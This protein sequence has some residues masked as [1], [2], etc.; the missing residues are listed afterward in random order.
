VM[1]VLFLMP[2]EPVWDLSGW[3]VLVFR[4][5]QAAGLTGLIVSTLQIEGGRFIGTTQ[6]IAYFKGD[7]LPL[8]PEPLKLDGVYGFVRHPLYLFSLMVLWFTPTMRMTWLVF[9][10]AST[11]YFIVG[12]LFEEHTMRRIFGKPYEEYQQR[13]PWMIPFFK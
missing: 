13:V 1:A 11:V 12:S 10:I 8:P 2:G 4:L 5:V 6:A 3:W 9:V 7:P